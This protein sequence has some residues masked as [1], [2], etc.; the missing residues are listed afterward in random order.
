M[1]R[2]LRGR[3]GRTGEDYQAY[4]TGLA[5]CVGHCHP[6]ARRSSVRLDRKRKKTTSNQDWRS[7]FVSVADFREGFKTAE[8]AVFFL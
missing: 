6:D 2:Q 8:E 1:V 5:H 4:L 7:P 3:R